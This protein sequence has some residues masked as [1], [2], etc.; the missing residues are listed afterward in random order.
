MN[1]KNII[2]ILITII[3]IAIV[4]VIGN[5]GA[6]TDAEKFKR[7][8]ENLNGEK[9][10]SGKSYR[11]LNISKN[12][13]IIYSTADEIVDKIDNKETFAVYFGFS[14]CPW[15][16]SILPTM[17]EVAEDL[18][19]DTIYYVDVLDIRDT[20][21]YKDGQVV[22]T[23]EGTDGYYAL[24]DRLSEVLDDYKIVD[25]EGKN[26]DSLEKRIYAPNIVAVVDGKPESMT[27]G[28]SD[29]QEDGYMSITNDM[30]KDMYNKIKCTLE[31]ISVE[32]TVCEKNVC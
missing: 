30:K 6:E 2:I 8:Y 20:K 28:I 25:E 22:D 19:I 12:N 7:E 23:K 10:D 18:G 24:L 32:A 21:E 15:C 27:T 3:L 1:K 26:V 11:E 5:K 16:R 13:P 31:C 14:K 17:F 4:F 29:K 9:N